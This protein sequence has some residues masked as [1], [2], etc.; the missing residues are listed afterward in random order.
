MAEQSRSRASKK[1][2]EPDILSIPAEQT[3]LDKTRRYCH[4]MIEAIAKKPQA[5]SLLRK[6]AD[7]LK[8]YASYKTEKTDGSKK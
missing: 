2:A 6:A 7:L 8:M 4:A 1:S 5:V 3:E